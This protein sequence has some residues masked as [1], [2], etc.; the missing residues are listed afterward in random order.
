MN[1]KK[2]VILDASEQ[3]HQKIEPDFK[4]LGARMGKLMKSVAA[5]VNGFSQAQIAELEERSHMP[6]KWKDRTWNCCATTWRSPGERARPQRGKRWRV[7]RCTRHHLERRFGA[8]RHRARAREPHPDLAERVRVRVTDRIDLRI[9]RNGDM[10]FEQA[11]TNHAPHI[12]SET[13][14]SPLRTSYLWRTWPVLPA[15]STRWTWTN[16]SPSRWRWADR[17]IEGGSRYIRGCVFQRGIAMAKKPAPKKAAK[18]AKKAARK[19]REAHQTE[20]SGEKSK[21]AP[22]ETGC[23]K[24][25]KAKSAP[26]KRPPNRSRNRSPKARPCEQ[27]SGGEAVVKTAPPV[28]QAPKPPRHPTQWQQNQ[29]SLHP[30]RPRTHL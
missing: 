12:L 28:K 27:E 30:G 6:C 1:V 15:K 11:V 8:G 17:P 21:P 24:P 14:A 22:E 25:V 7:D 18:P 5:A 19:S 3:T 2:L 20:G 16:G 23:Q 13:L 29:P 26:A 4:K 9:Q 10:A